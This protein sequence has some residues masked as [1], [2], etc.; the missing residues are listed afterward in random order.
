MPRYH[1]IAVYIIANRKQGALYT[2]VTSDLPSRMALHKIGRGSAFAAEYGCDRL[3]WFMRYPEMRPAIQH[4][5]RIK[6]WKRQWKIE[7]IEEANPDWR[8]LSAELSVYGW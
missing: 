7:L 3:I 1:F 5:K 4:E 6:R 2:G 8:D